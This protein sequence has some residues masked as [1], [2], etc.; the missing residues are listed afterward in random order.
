MLLG[1]ESVY[2]LQRIIE[3]N[4]RAYAAGELTPI[5]AV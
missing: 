5:V 4:A 1:A 2:V 3:R